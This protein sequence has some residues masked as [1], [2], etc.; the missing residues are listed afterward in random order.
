MSN[1]AA[2]RDMVEKTRD[3]VDIYK[4]GL[5][6]FT[7]FGPAVLDT[8]R[9][10]G[11]QLFLDL[12]YHDIPNTVAQAVRAAAELRVDYLTIHT[13]G[14]LAMMQAA[15][16]AARSTDHALHIIGVTVL[17]SISQSALRNEANVH[18]PLHAQVRHLAQMAAV[19]RLD[20]IVCSAA[21]LSVVRPHLPRKFDIICPG[22]R[23]PGAQ[24][25]DQERI[26]TPAKAV[27]DGATILVVGRPITSADDPTAVAAAIRKEMGEAHQQ[28]ADTRFHDTV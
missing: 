10:S 24:A 8:I 16:E 26:A 23:P 13:M 21:D 20:G 22:I 11:K 4:I 3:S 6:Q 15:A 25:H 28:T 14:G 19:S 2:I 18:V 12:K 7:R 9:S 27:A 17:T 1:H 5:E